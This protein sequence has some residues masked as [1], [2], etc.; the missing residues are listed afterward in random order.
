MLDLTVEKKV[1]I[2]F[3]VFGVILSFVGSIITAISMGMMETSFMDMPVEMIHEGMGLI[4]IGSVLGLIATI[5]LLVVYHQWSSVLNMNVENTINIFEYLKQKDPDKVFEYDKFLK[6]L[7]N[8]KIPN[9]PYWLFFI[10]MVL[11]WFFPSL[12]ILPV[13]SIIFFL[14]HLHNIFSVADRLQELKGKAYMEFGDLP[15][16]VKTIETRNVLMV[17]LFTLITLGIY[18]VYLIIKLSSEINTF[19]EKDKIARQVILS[20]IG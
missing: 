15:K 5:L 6:S 20:K 11:Y 16:D 4:V 1:N 12:V 18:W 8:M 3:A 9:W 13:L 10:F 14:V 19:V 7:K 17:L 2:G